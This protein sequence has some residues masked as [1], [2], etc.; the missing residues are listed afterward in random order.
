MA[1]GVRAATAGRTLGFEIKRTERPS[2]TR[3]MR[4]A[5]ADLELDRLYVVHAGAHRF[6]L[7]ERI[8]AIGAVELLTGEELPDAA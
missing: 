4:N 5:L 7:D 6:A 2:V 3:S 1:Y 8:T